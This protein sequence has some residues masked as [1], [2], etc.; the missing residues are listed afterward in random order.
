MSAETAYRAGAAASTPAIVAAESSLPVPTSSFA[1]ASL[2]NAQ[3]I[4][5]SLVSSFAARKR[6]GKCFS[7]FAHNVCS[8]AASSPGAAA[9]PWLFRTFAGI[10]EPRQR[11]GGAVLSRRKS[12]YARQMLKSMA[13]ARMA[14]FEKH[15]AAIPSEICETAENRLSWRGL[16]CPDDARKSARVPRPAPSATAFTQARK[17]V[18]AV[19]AL[20]QLSSAMAS[21]AGQPGPSCRP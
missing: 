19:Y 8:L 4:M 6:I 17:F 11:H 2:R 15:H 3:R 9:R 12:A 16:L 7:L 5:S 18:D 1:A 14:S 13:G 21:S 20:K 10:D